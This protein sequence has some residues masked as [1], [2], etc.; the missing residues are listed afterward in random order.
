MSSMIRTFDAQMIFCFGSN[1]RGR[2]GAGA[3]RDAVQRFGAIEGQGEGVQGNSYAIPTKDGNIQTL[4]LD[5]IERHVARFIDF[6]RAH[7]EKCFQVTR[8]GCGLAGYKDAD[9]APF[10]KE[11]PDN[12]L[13]PGIWEHHR[14]RQATRI[15]IAG[16]RDFD[17]RTFAFPRIS[18]MLSRVPDGLEIISG[19]ARGADTIGEE[20]AA[21]NKVQCVR[22]PAQWD[23]YGKRAGFIRNAMMGWYATHLIAFWDGKSPGTRGMIDFARENGLQVKVFELPPAK[24][25]SMPPM[26]GL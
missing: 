8:I 12:V 4:P 20:W 26:K 14:G 21:Q 25:K 13:L 1:L 11:A 18:H 16:S 15:I 3:A 24:P 17:D 7:P 23:Q 22:F 5:Q 9:I 19:G 2:H 6:A 10:F